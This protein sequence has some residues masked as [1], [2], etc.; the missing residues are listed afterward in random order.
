MNTAYLIASLLR[1]HVG[2]FAPVVVA[3]RNYIRRCHVVNSE[4]TSL[5]NL[6]KQTITNVKYFTHVQKYLQRDSLEA[7]FAEIPASKY[8]VVVLDN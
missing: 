6:A 5:R 1:I 3:W 7:R 2:K 4:Y 8:F